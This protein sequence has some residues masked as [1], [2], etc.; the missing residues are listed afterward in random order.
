MT[1]S[2]FSLGQLQFM[3]LITAIAAANSNAIAATADRPAPIAATAVYNQFQRYN[4]NNYGRYNPHTRQYEQI[5][6]YNARYDG[7]Y[8]NNRYNQHNQYNQYNP[9]NNGYYQRNYNN[10][11][12]NPYTGKYEYDSRYSPYTGHVENN[13]YDGQYYQNTE[14]ARRLS[15]E[16][17]GRGSVDAVHVPVLRYSDEGRWNV[18]RDDRTSSNDGDYHYAYE[19][20][21]GI[22]AAEDSQ[23][24][25]KHTAVE[26]SKKTG[27]YEY[28][29]DDGKTY[30]VDW[31]ADENGFRAEV[32]E[33]Q[34]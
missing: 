7:T 18:L 22:R 1:I 6:P 20:E 30:R 19:T 27:F 11:Y 12:F 21:N 31:V 15:P 14:F 5:N 3:G 8:Y 26:S 23:Q 32:R 29:G 9:Y 17:Y 16:V 33:C 2:H 10:G 28:V 13:R 24:V 34:G 4:S 25:N